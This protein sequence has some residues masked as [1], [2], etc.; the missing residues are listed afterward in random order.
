MTLH[1]LTGELSLRLARLEAVA[2]DEASVR[3]VADLRHESETVPLSGLSSVIVRAV[4][5]SDGLCWDSLTR[6]DAA[7][8]IRQAAVCDE[9]CEFGACAGLLGP[10]G[11]GSR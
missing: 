11:C 9:L 6:G 10:D 2:T 1:Y 5:L 7:G 8:F 4:A 3:R